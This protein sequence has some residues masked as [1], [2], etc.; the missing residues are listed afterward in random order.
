MICHLDIASIALHK[1]SEAAKQQIQREEGIFDGKNA[2]QL[3]VFQSYFML[4]IPYIYYPLKY[5]WISEGSEESKMRRASMKV[6][7]KNKVVNVLKGT[8]VDILQVSFS[9]NPFP[10][11]Y[12][13]YWINTGPKIDLN[14]DDS[15]DEDDSSEEDDRSKSKVIILIVL[16]QFTLLIIL[17]VSFVQLM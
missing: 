6:I 10:R 9:K 16:K 1:D 5:I 12:I 15:D 17:I 13:L 8:I 14:D 4:A 3:L 11:K 2:V 7:N